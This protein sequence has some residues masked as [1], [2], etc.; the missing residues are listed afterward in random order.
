MAPLTAEQL[1]T[2]STG[3]GASEI[4]AVAGLSRWDS[5]LTVYLR[6]LGLSDDKPSNDAIEAGNELE[7]AICAWAGKRLGAELIEVG[8]VRHSKHA[9]ALC[10]PDRVFADRSALLQ[11]K[12]VG[13]RMAHEWGDDADEVPDAYRAQVEWEMEV[14]EINRA[15]LAVLVGGQT[16][17]IYQFDRDRELAASL[18]AIGGKFWREHVLAQVPPPIDGSDKTRAWLESQ[19]PSSIGKLREAP[20]E[21][22][23]W[24]RRY[25][26][27]SAAAKL[28]EEEKALAG[29]HLRALIGADEGV[30]SRWGKATWKSNA[31]G[32]P[33]W[34]E[35][36]E[37]L[38]ATPSVIARFTGAAPRVLRV[39]LKGN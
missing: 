19:H 2:R 27:A 32:T 9:F 24:A 6:K 22:E 38:G 20:A 26:A 10:T 35:I 8:T 33:R 18:I 1:A 4:G 30:M 29:N 34:K 17:R 3:I 7:P 14:T 31:S 12:N 13:L 23:D 36:A 28:A 39:A 15:F 11:V 16:L 5:P 37:H 25:V 21:A